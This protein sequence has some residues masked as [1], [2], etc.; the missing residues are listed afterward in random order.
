MSCDA[1][2]FVEAP[3]NGGRYSLHIA[4]RRAQSLRIEALTPLGDPAAVLVADAG[5]FA[6]LDLRHDVF[7]RGSSSPEN[8]SRLLPAPLR[9]DEL[10]SLLTGA[11]PELPAAEPVL[12]ER[13][14][15]GWHLRLSTVAPGTT[16]ILGYVQDLWLGTDLRI[17]EVRRSTTGGA[18]LWTVRLDE[19]DDSSGVLL[20]RLIHLSVPE[21]KTEIDL[22]LK[23]LLAQ[24]PPP[25]GAFLLGV[26]QGMR[27]EELP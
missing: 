3:E 1:K 13:A 12:L 11:F 24:K 19:F 20:P 25:G 26:P 7:Y 22:K 9:A 14:G 8:L 17:G 10:V 15:D 27:V 23:N 2:A 21:K 6:L 4:A 18:L 16:T 5:R